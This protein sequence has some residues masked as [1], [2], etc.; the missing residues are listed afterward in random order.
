L[1]PSDEETV[2][3]VSEFE[4]IVREFNSRSKWDAVCGTIAVLGIAALVI[5]YFLFFR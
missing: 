5:A 4:S 1:L 2:K 3:A